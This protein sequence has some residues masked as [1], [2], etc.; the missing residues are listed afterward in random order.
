MYERADGDIEYLIEGMLP[1]G[2]IMLL[3]ARPKVGKSE[4]ARNLAYAVV[5]GGEF[6]GR[7]VQQGAVLWLA[8]EEQPAIITERMQAL[9]V[10]RDLPWLYRCGAAPADALAWLTAAV[11][12]VKPKLIVVDTF[13]R[14]TRVDNLNDYSMVTKATE[15]LLRLSRERGAAQLWLHHN[16]K[17]TDTTRG[18]LGSSA[19][20]GTVDTTMI[21]TRNDDNLR[22][23]Y[24]EQR[25]GFD[26]EEALITMD[27]DTYRITVSDQRFIAE[28]RAVE[29]LVLDAL[30]VHEGGLSKGELLERIPRRASLVRS[31]VSSLV[32][33]GFVIAVGSGV[34]GDAKRYTLRPL[35]VSSAP[36]S[37]ATQAAAERL[38]AAIDGELDLFAYAQARL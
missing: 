4:L 16:N 7:R 25:S 10:T 17:A 33:A 22:F 1:A 37:I 6:L 36:T 34:R 5:T 27:P 32:S 26:M 38:D 30:R 20:V 14:L 35:V 28:Q 15:P 8:M 18:V 24:T 3:S 19:L 31:A 21:L 2:G 13:N 9:G 11:D 29:R 23:A 12:K